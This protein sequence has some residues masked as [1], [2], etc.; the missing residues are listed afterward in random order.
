MAIS[1]ATTAI[2][3][4]SSHFI[5]GFL[6]NAQMKIENEWCHAFSCKSKRFANSFINCS[7]FTHS[8][9]LSQFRSGNQFKFSSLNIDSIYGYIYDIHWMFESERYHHKKENYDCSSRL[10]DEESN[11]KEQQVSQINISLNNEVD[12]WEQTPVSNVGCMSSKTDFRF[13]S[14]I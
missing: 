9:V 7:T 3:L 11:Q 8:K 5:L 2:S 10:S 14:I 6:L 12:L 4:I 13:E 1:E